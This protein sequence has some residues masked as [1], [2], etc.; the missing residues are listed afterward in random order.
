MKNA[1]KG[2]L[3]SGL[4][5]PGLGQVVLKHYARGVFIM[6]TVLLSLSVAVMKAVQY[7]LVI[8]EKTE[9][10]GGDIDLSAIINAATHASGSADSLT[11]NLLLL[12]IVVCWIIGVVDAY[13]IGRKIDIEERSSRMVSNGDDTNP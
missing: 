12:L 9:L 5:L 13:R 11:L 7:A 2:A 1:L 4:I 6:L 3:L 8:L 10:E